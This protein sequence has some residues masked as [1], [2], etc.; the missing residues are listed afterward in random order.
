MCEDSVRQ[1][2]SQLQVTPSN[3]DSVAGAFASV[4]RLTKSSRN[5][6]FQRRLRDSHL[7]T[8]PR[9]LSE[10]EKTLC[11]KEQM[12]KE[13]IVSQIHE[14]FSPVLQV[15]Y[16]V[17]CLQSDGFDPSNCS[18]DEYIGHMDELD[19]ICGRGPLHDAA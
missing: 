11:S 2:Y 12:A 14:D 7:S 17:L 16:H 18:D 8:K 13:K 15:L 19:Y 6:I 4:V 9:P 1:F 10:A 3:Q 5:K